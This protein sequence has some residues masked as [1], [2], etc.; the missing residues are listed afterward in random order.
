MRP[1]TYEE[2]DHRH[3]RSERPEEALLYQL[4]QIIDDFAVDAIVVSDIDGGL[5]AH[6]GGT[7]TTATA[8]STE[9]QRLANGSHCRLMYARLTRAQPS[10]RQN[11]VSACEFRI[12]ARRLFVTALGG[13]A[14]MRDVAM[15][16]AVLGFKRILG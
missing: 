16:R 2:T 12:G 15:M 4:R 8:L 5:V 14:T 6:A 10:I 11:R 9:A 3:Q 13:S 1:T 7:I